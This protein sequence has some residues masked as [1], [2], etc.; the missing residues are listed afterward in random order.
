MQFDLVVAVVK[1]RIEEAKTTENSVQ[2]LGQ[3]SIE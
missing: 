3:K 1:I 2:Y